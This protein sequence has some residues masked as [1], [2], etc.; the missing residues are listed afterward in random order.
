[1]KQLLCILLL[2]GCCHTKESSKEDSYGNIVVDTITSI[3]DGDSFRCTIKEY[4]PIIGHRIG[5]RVYGIDTPELRDKCPKVKEKA[6]KAKQFAVAL[7]RGAEKVELRNLRRDKYFRILAEVYVDGKSLAQELMDAGHA[8]P[9][10]GGTKADWAAEL[11]C[12]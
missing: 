1:M 2:I 10:D 11:G 4:P 3:Y 8:K 7:L 6:Q 9:Y 5:I 12:E